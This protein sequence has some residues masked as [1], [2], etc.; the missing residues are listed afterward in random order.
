MIRVRVM[1]RNVRAIEAILGPEFTVERVADSRD[2]D[3]SVLIVPPEGTSAQIPTL[4]MVE[5]SKVLLAAK[6]GVTGIL[7]ADRIHSSLPSAVRLLAEGYRI[8][9]SPERWIQSAGISVVQLRIWRLVSQGM[10]N[11]EIG[12]ELGYSRRQVERLVA[13]LLSSLGVQ[14]GMD[15]TLLGSALGGFPRVMRH[16]LA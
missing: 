13:R 10:T 8:V 12:G 7:L 14:T 5:P 11:E 4:A 1:T 6:R 3:W 9:P 2:G 16:R 15:A